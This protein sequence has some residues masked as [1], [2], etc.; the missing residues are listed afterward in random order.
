MSSSS[1]SLPSSER[2]PTWAN[3]LAR[4][5]RS[6]EASHFLLYHNVFDLVRGR[7]GF[8]SLPGFLQK[9]LLGNKQIV[10]YNRSEGISFD[11]EQTQR[12]FLAQQRVA[13]PLLNI[14]SASQ[15][16]RDPARALPMIERFLYFADRVAVIIN[17]LETIFPAGEFGQLSS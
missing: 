7:S 8:V 6:G 2:L 3:E 11:S 10:S 12:A 4:K 14:T 9:E 17:F 15:L 16:P 1:H 13:D 5:Y